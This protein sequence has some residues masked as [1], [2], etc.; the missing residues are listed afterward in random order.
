MAIERPTTTRQLFD[1]VV[2]ENK[3]KHNLPRGSA[4]LTEAITL[5]RTLPQ[6]AEPPETE[7]PPDDVH[8]FADL[9]RGLRTLYE[10]DA[11]QAGRVA[12]T[13]EATRTIKPDGKRLSPRK[14]RREL[15]YRR[16]LFRR[17]IRW[18][19]VAKS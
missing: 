13:L 18:N 3:G 11:A 17:E 5:M 1:R 19:D 9:G 16:T 14:V 4:G 7:A 15:G 6:I 2:A 8:S 10:S 12:R